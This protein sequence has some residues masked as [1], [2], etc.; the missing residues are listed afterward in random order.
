MST[1]SHQREKAIFLGASVLAPADIPAYVQ[2][3]CGDDYELLQGVYALLA[4]SAKSEP[5]TQVVELEEATPE[6]IIGERGYQLIRALGEGGMGQVFL[7]ERS[8]GSFR[9]RV[10][11]KLMHRNLRLSRDA[12]KRFRAERQILASLNHPNIARLIDGGELASGVPF[13]VLEYVEG[14]A[15]DAYCERHGL[16]ARGR[17]RLIVKVCEAVQS[18]HQALVVHRDLKPSNILIT[19]AGEPK[20]LDFG[21]AKVLNADAQSLLQTRTGA[22]PM[23]LA[24]ASPEQVRGEAVGT[25]SDVY[26]L[27]VVLYQLLTGVLPYRVSSA[28]PVGM[29]RAI[30]DQAPEVP[31]RHTRDHL[32]VAN[33]PVPR[34]PAGAVRSN[35]RGDLDAIT[36]KALRKEP[37]ERYGSVEQLAADLTRFLDG[38]PVLARHGSRWYTTRKFLA[39][40]RVAVAAGVL[41]ALGV[42]AF[43]LTLQYQLTQV[44]IERDKARA[45]SS[46]LISMVDRS[47][48]ESERT[49]DSASDANIRVRDII[50]ESAPRIETELSAFPEAQA[51]LL[52]VIARVYLNMDQLEPAHRYGLAALDKMAAT[53]QI[54]S[55]AS[56]DARLFLLLPLYARSDVKTLLE[57]ADLAV[58]DA[59]AVT[60]G[61]SFI[62]ARALNSR[63]SFYRVLGRLDEATRD[64]EAALAMMRKVKPATSAYIAVALKEI[65]QI[66]NL[67]GDFERCEAV[68]REAMHGWP[69]K[70]GPTHIYYTSIQSLHAVCLNQLGRFDEAQAELRAALDHFTAIRGPDSLST[71]RASLQL[72]R[73]L[74]Q[75]GRHAEAEPLIRAALAIYRREFGEAHAEVGV[76]LSD[77]GEA[78]VAPP[79]NAEAVESL[80]AALDLVKANPP[81]RTL[82]QERLAQQLARGG[83]AEEAE[84]LWREALA[85]YDANAHEHPDRAIALVHLGQMLVASARAGEALPLLE[86]ALRLAIAKRPPGHW[87]IAEARAALA[88]AMRR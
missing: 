17:V 70:L 65:A 7:A 68:A 57:Q 79:Q 24:Y 44:E 76:V 87:R 8:D 3:Q 77:L 15:I 83:H 69:A 46:F 18:A 25:S 33:P 59:R 38:E 62:L 31:S 75:Q 84:P 36:L 20:L 45:M 32:T 55:E 78:L 34:G 60:Q 50:D 86:E 72:G 2:A 64:A 11:I 53:G 49:H 82:A 58:A 35:L 21:I 73:Q 47:D 51:S 80:R 63:G 1:P 81:M 4:A 23:T 54:P 67:T 40:H 85:W 56:A 48:P 10:A 29:A 26:S 71:G 43:V 16:D 19:S 9:Q 66:A 88:K 52:A 12:G 27:G 13:L 6:T 30:C 22:M 74:N 61:D 37:R 28:D 41:G 39:R 5:F 14:L 42:L